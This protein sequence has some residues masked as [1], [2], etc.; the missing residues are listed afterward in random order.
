MALALY[1]VYL[2]AFLVLPVRSVLHHSLPPAS[3]VVITCE[4]I[5]L[6]MKTH[7][8]V[9]ENIP[10]VFQN[11]HKNGN[12]ETAYTVSYNLIGRFVWNNV[13]AAYLF[14]T[15]LHIW[16]AAIVIADDEST[17]SPCPPFS[18][19]LYF[20]FA[21]TLIYRDTYPRLVLVSLKKKTIR[22]YLISI[23]DL[24]WT[25]F[26][27]HNICSIGD[28]YNTVL[29]AFICCYIF[30][31]IYILCL[32]S[33]P[34]YAMYRTRGPV[35]WRY[36]VSNFTQVLA[37]LFYVY[38]IFMRFCIPVFRDF[39]QEHW[40]PKRL[41]LTV[42][43]CM[44]PGT[45]VLLLGLL[46]RCLIGRFV[47]YLMP[48]WSICKLVNSDWLDALLLL[49][50]CSVFRHSPFLAERFCRNVTLRWSPVL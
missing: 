11:S 31:K 47:D 28:I 32:Y 9:R 45:L 37:C 26:V 1:I 22:F 16:L 6:L 20:L 7:A 5:R 41:L 15:E 36:V 35:R 25:F 12:Y 33:M 39:S 30:Y 18:K 29:V 44:M 42:F 3:S 19:Y 34:C 10:K 17:S 27:Q 50:S 38:Y 14:I 40:L 48:D 2:L 24:F 8:F 21:P 46:I 43:G 4:Q 13:F 23:A 49:C